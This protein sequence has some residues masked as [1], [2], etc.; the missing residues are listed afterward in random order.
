[1]DAYDSALHW[2][3]D[4]TG[5]D[6]GNF[7]QSCPYGVEQVLDAGFYPDTPAA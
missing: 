2:A 3:A 7:P 6:E 5:M 4:E 1:M